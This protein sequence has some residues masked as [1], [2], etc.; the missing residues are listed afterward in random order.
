MSTALSV[1]VDLYPETYC[2]ILGNIIQNIYRLKGP[3][4][5]MF[6]S[7]NFPSLELITDCKPCQLYFDPSPD[8]ADH[9]I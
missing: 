9:L 7:K 1:S 6:F 3:V 5:S 2:A 4:Q 8:E